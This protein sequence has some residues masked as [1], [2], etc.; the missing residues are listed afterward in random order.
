MQSIHSTPSFL[1]DS[2]ILAAESLEIAEQN[3]A[4]DVHQASSV[5]F[6]PNTQSAN[7]KPALDKPQPVL[8]GFYESLITALASLAGV[9]GEVTDSMRIELNFKRVQMRNLLQDK[10]RDI[11]AIA[12]R[13]AMAIKA[14]REMVEAKERQGIFGRVINFA[15]AAGEMIGG[16]ATLAAGVISGQP[17]LIAGGAMLVAAGAMEMVAEV[18]DMT[19]GS[20]TAVKA[21]KG[22][23]AGALII[24]I[25]LTTYGAGSAAATTFVAKKG[26]REVSRT[27]AKNAAKEAAEKASQEGG[28]ALLKHNIKSAILK[29]GKLAGEFRGKVADVSSELIA[30]QA[31][32]ITSKVD[33]ITS[34]IFGESVEKATQRTLDEA[35][36]TTARL[37]DD[38]GQRALNNTDNLLIRA[39]ANGAKRAASEASEKAAKHAD[40]I[41]QRTMDMYESSVKNMKTAGK[42]M[43]V[44]AGAAGTAT[45]AY[46]GALKFESRDNQQRMN[47]IEAEIA[48]LQ[49]ALEEV[50]QRQDYINKLI[51]LIQEYAARSVSEPVNNTLR[52][53][54]D[55]IQDTHK[56]ASAILRHGV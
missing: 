35:A 42:V 51:Q 50:S 55:V 23:A 38:I 28:A 7:L 4:R 19:G 13:K 27:A 15:F 33:D 18:V 29:P 49:A 2:T 31:K 6:D 10:L 14:E 17:S 11:D 16:V 21:L 40:D 52:I 48:V 30:K 24:G 3:R 36:A 43:A 37:A 8:G 53:I 54:N 20:H 12:E 41:Q 44:M 32:K 39:Q 26:A 25:G 5:T 1:R 45:G 47:E 9:M 56:A 46:G 34:R 22:A